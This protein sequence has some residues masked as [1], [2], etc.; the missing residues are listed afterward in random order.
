MLLSSISEVTSRCSMWRDRTRFDRSAVKKMH[1]LPISHI[2]MHVQ[3]TFVA[4]SVSVCILPYSLDPPPPRFQPGVHTYVHLWVREGSVCLTNSCCHRGKPIMGACRGVR[5]SPQHHYTDCQI[6]TW[7]GGQHLYVLNFIL[8]FLHWF[9]MFSPQSWSL[10]DSSK[11]GI[12]LNWKAN[13][14]TA[15]EL[16][17]NFMHK[18]LKWFSKKKKKKKFKNSPPKKQKANKQH[19]RDLFELC[20][21]GLSYALAGLEHGASLTQLFC[22]ALIGQDWNAPS[23]LQSF[24]RRRPPHEDSRWAEENFNQL[25][26]GWPSVR[27]N[28]EKGKEQQGRTNVAAPEKAGRQLRPN[29]SY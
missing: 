6:P 20:S 7:L 2:C 10:T 14:T 9:T 12:S 1:F 18:Y 23:C 29:V 26:G 25:R 17:L 22:Q 11:I 24:V 15:A 28:W 8:Y 27:R 3:R 4:V 21:W 16:R 19:P 13:L 5:N